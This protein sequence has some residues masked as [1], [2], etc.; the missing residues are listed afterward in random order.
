[1]Y[2]LPSR[3]PKKPRRGQGKKKLKMLQRSHKIRI[4]NQ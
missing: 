2:Q 1:M 3:R 4:D